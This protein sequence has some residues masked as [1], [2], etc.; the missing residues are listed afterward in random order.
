ML[1]NWNLPGWPNFQY[2]TRELEGILLKYAQFCGKISGKLDGLD[3]QLRRETLIDFMVT[4][5]IKT[6]KIEGENLNFHDVKSS[7]K[8]QLGLNKPLQHVADLRADGIAKMMLHVHDTYLQPLTEATLFEW[9]RSLFLGQS[10]AAQIETGKWRTHD[11][12]MQIVSGPYGKWKVHFEAPPSARVPTLMKQF[13]KWF[14]EKTVVQAPI[15]SGIAHLYFES[16]HPFEDG[17]GRIGRAI[18]EKVLLQQSPFETVLGLSASIEAKK[19]VYYDALQKAQ[20]SNEITQWLHYFVQML[21]D[22]QEAVAASIQFII[23]RA[24]FMKL[25]SAHANDRQLK[26]LNRVLEEGSGN[27][28]G[29]LNAKKYGTITK[30][31]K[32]TATRELSELLEKNLIKRLP[33]GG[34]STSYELN[35]T[36]L[37]K[38]TT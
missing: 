14:N 4:E 26:V 5:A 31:S 10:G 17:N 25:A 29:G 9:H 28:V 12:P 1:Y 6:S 38:I 27:F 15:R 21:L 22:A 13:L 37:N 2:E 32:T 24:N 8:N 36:P 35:L 3:I 34:R 30:C 33:G 11:E 16:I 7:I 23:D 19:K 18:S 20:R